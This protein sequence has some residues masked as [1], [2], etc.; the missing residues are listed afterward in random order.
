MLGEEA[1]RLLFEEHPRA[2]PVTLVETHDPGGSTG[3]S[4]I[5]WAL[6]LRPLDGLDH[7]VGYV[8]AQ[9]RGF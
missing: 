3:S 7:H 4:R 1:G 5:G 6:V 9:Q 8:H 2:G